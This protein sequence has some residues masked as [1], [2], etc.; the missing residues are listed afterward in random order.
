MV[1]RVIVLGGGSA[2]FLVAITLKTK[3]PDLSVAVIRSKDIGIIGVGEGTTVSVPNFLHGYLNIDP[4]E[5]HRVARPTYKLGLRFEWGQRP[6]FH[7]TFAPQFDQQIRVLSRPN[8]FYCRE[9]ADLQNASVNSAMMTLG[10]AFIRLPDG[11]PGIRNDAA[12]H[13]ENADFVTFLETHARRVGVEIIDDTVEGVE[14]DDRGVA[15][16]NC[17]E[18]G[19]QR[20]ELFVDCS[21]FF[22]VLLSKTLG[23]PFVSFNTSLFCDRAVVGGW[24]RPEGEPI[25]PY[26]TAATMDAGWCWQIEHDHRVNRGYVYASAF[27]SDADAVAEF[28]RKNPRVEATRVVKFVS[29]RYQRGWVKNVV[30]IGNSNGFVEPLESTSLAVI[31]EE[32]HA[33]AASLVDSF[34]DPGPA[35]VAQYNKRNSQTWDDIRRFLAV[36]YRFN[37]RLD[38]PFWRAARAE[39][40]L[41]GAEEFV[42]FYE[43]NGPTLAWKRLLISGRDVFGFEGWLTM[44]VGQK[45]PYRRAFQPDG[46]ERQVWRAVQEANRSQAAAGHTVR[47]TLQIIRSPQWRA[48]PN[49]FRYP[50]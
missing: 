46:H 9:D 25:L 45:V 21:G 44:M 27:L 47:D 32:C 22:S 14:Q 1:N 39:T 6:Y 10:K 18:T 41:A 5:F 48:R 4:L 29:G 42:E 24:A 49:F 35:L 38:T 28:R 16:V 13:I 40:D 33:L 31:C 50:Y 26:T 15:A 17:R 43:E 23:E 7:Y 8:G 20:A 36:H 2:G 34:R 3:L 37:T 11:S 12:Y 30:A 19:R